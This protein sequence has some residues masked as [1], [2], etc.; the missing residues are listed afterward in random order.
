MN[1]TGEGNTAVSD[2]RIRVGYFGLC[3][4]RSSQSEW[5]CAS[6]ASG[7]QS[8]IAGSDTD[9]LDIL[10][11]GVSFKNDVLFPGLL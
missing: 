10:H 11:T 2:L 1:S 8:V 6:G 9:P 7:L 3:A 4:Q 5:V